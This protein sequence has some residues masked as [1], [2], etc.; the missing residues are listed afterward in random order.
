MDL[1]D[2]HPA[3]AAEVA[4]R[5]IVRRAVLGPILLAVVNT[6]HRVLGVKQVVGVGFVGAEHGAGGDV[7]G[8]QLAHGGLSLLLDDES[9]G[10]LCAHAFIVGGMA[11]AHHHDAALVG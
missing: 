8:H 9:Q 7:L 6:T 1:A 3:Q 4:L 2:L 10:A 11:L 5:L